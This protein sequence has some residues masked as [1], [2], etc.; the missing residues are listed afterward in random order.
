MKFET[1]MDIEAPIGFVFEEI[2]NFKALERAAMRRGAEV[3]RVDSLEAPG[4]GMAWDAHFKLRGKERD[5]QM[6]ISEYDP[7]NGLT[8]SSRSPS[9]GGTMV[10]E[11]VPLSKIRTRVSMT[12]T[13]APKNL[14]AK[15]LVQS[16]KLAKKNLMKRLDE[17]MEGYATEIAAR[18]RKTV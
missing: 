6:E 15:L 16:M 4:V 17:R 10:V 5:V 11:L 7:P 12:V 2:T 3:Q 1:K 18:Y 14:S 13:L 8:V 9:M